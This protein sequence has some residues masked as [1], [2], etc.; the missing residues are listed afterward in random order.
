M[1]PTLNQQELQNCGDVLQSKG[2]LEVSAQARARKEYIEE[3]KD[4][5]GR[6]QREICKQLSLGYASI[7]VPEVWLE[8]V[9]Q[10]LVHRGLDY[11]L[12]QP[13]SGTNMATV[14]VRWH[15]DRALTPPELPKDQPERKPVK[16]GECGRLVHYDDGAGPVSGHCRLTADHI[17]DCDLTRRVVAK[18]CDRHTDCKQMLHHRGAC[19]P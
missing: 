12:K 9:E 1:D 7:E 15:V 4:H 5:L 3:L 2:D 16:P 19:T 18:R 8:P 10:V 13:P 14:T 6:L 17:G 11:D